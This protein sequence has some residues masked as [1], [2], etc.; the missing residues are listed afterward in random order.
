MADRRLLESG[1]VRLLE[2]GDARLLERTTVDTTKRSDP[3]RLDTIRVELLDQHENV[4]GELHPDW[5]SPPTVEVD[6]GATIPR[7]LTGIR[8]DASEAADIDVYSDRLRPVWTIGGEDHRLGLFVWS[9]A[10]HERHGWGVDL[11]SG[12]AHDRTL[13]L[14]QPLTESFGVDEGATL[15]DR[16]V[17]LIESYGIHTHDVDPSDQ[18]ASS[19][20]SWPAGKPGTKALDALTSKLS[21]V[22]WFDRDGRLRAGLEPDPDV[23]A[24]DRWYEEAH[25]RPGVGEDDD[26]WQRPNVWLVVNE[27]SEASEVTG[28]Y[29]LPS[30]HEASAE[31]RGFEVVEVVPESGLS[32]TA[33]ADKRARQAADRWA[34]TREIEIVTQPDPQSDLYGIVAWRGTPYREVAWSLPLAPG[35]GHSHTLRRQG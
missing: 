2:S 15:T 14:R 22:W 13:I 18:T 31:N 25:A 10:S 33:A 21:Y 6:V 12:T 35:A 23:H 24:P 32:S 20:L 1:G 17:D 8:L 4:I 28:T 16:I 34:L 5:E 30:T 3:V 26:L 19:P 7:R 27:S 29:R 11:R 9:T